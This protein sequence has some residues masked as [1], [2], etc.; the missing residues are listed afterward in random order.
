MQ[1]EISF[2]GVPLL[3]DQALVYRVQPEYNPVEPSEL[4]S[5]TKHQ[6]LTDFIDEINRLMPYQYLSDFQFPSFPSRNILGVALTDENRQPTPMIRINDFYYPNN[7]SRWAVFRG[8]ATSSMV[9]SINTAV[10]SSN[11]QTYGTFKINSV[12]KGRDSSK[13]GISTSLYMLPPRII[14]E[15]ESAEGLYL[16]T[17]VDERYFFQGTPA[18][19]PLS[20]YSTWADIINY[21]AVTL[22]ISLSFSNVLDSYQRPEPDSA[23][24]TTGE[25]AASL[26][27]AAA[28]NIGT[29]VVRNYDG[30]Y[31]LY[32]PSDSVSI[33]RS[34]R[35]NASYSLSTS[36]GA[37]ADGSVDVLRIAGGRLYPTAGISKAGDR[38]A[39]KNIV[40]PQYIHVTFPKYVAGNDPVPH[41]VNSRYRNPRATSWIEDSYGSVYSIAVPIASG[42]DLVSGLQ[43]V[44][45]QYIHETAKALYNTEAEAISFPLNYS[46][47]VDLAVQVAS[48]FYSYRI[49][50]NLDETYPGVVNWTPE[51][52]HDIIFTVSDRSRLSATR[53]IRPSWTLS[54]TELQ[55]STPIVSG[56]SYV[57]PG[58]GGTSVAQ[59]YKDSYSFSGTVL[60][61]TLGASLASG[62]FTATFTGINHLPTQN[63]W[64][65]QVENEIL[66]F[67]G[68]SGGTTVGIAQRGIDGTLQVAHDNGK[69]L[70]WI[71][72]DTA[73]G[74]NLV[75]F[76]KSQ[77]IH[78][79]TVSSGGIS[80]VTVLPQMQ[81]VLV[82]DGTG[83]VLSGITYHSGIVTYFNAA[84]A[85]VWVSGELVWITERNSGIQLTQGTR[86][87]A[88]L[89][90]YNAQIGT[91]NK[92]APVYLT[93]VGGGGGA[94]FYLTAKDQYGNSGTFLGS[95]FSGYVATTLGAP[96]NSGDTTAS[97]KDISYF[98]T[99]NRW[100]GIITWTSG[101]GTVTEKLLFEG[102]SGIGNFVGDGIEVSIVSGQRGIDGTSM[103]LVHPSGA[104]LVR[105]IIPH[106]TS[107]INTLTW[108]KSQ[109]VYPQEVS[110]E[111]GLTGVNLPALNQTIRIADGSGCVI[112]NIIHYSGV[113]TNFDPTIK[114]KPWLTT[115]YVWV[116]ERG[117]TSV[118]YSG[119]TYSG[120]LSGGFVSGSTY[121]GGNFSG[122][123]LSGFYFSGKF[124]SGI[125][126]TYV[127][128]GRYYQG[129]L[130]GYSAFESGR[131]RVVAPV[132][133]A[134]HEEESMLVQAT[135]KDYNGA[136]ITYSWHRVDEVS[137]AYRTS[138]DASP[139]HEFRLES[140]GPSSWPLYHEQNID[141]PTWP[142]YPTWRE[143]GLLLSGPLSGGFRS[144]GYSGTA[145]SGMTFSG[146][147]FS[148]ALVS[149]G[150]LQKL[151]TVRVYKGNGDYYLTNEKP[152]EDLFR[153]TATTDAYGR[154]GYLRYYDQNSGMWT[155][156]FE[157]RIADA[158]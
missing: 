126:Q 66:L 72:P 58:A 120:H 25:N 129:Q 118:S 32:T 51:G 144:Q 28:Y 39:F 34:N 30:T 77:F 38:S 124:T 86:Y 40:V 100:R 44:S 73:Y 148:G 45:Q 4:M 121:S 113:V 9:K 91:L 35:G 17:L 145:Y 60:S 46:G 50:P 1:Y 83:T 131:V 89:A 133:A 22:G 115:D 92:V 15:T 128:S 101:I 123:T 104:S 84:G 150:S 71:Q 76:G 53:V 146:Q 156:G 59:T 98:P 62:D 88:Q 157:V 136:A 105:E 139:N 69:T 135:Y 117:S 21:L 43:G 97:F 125:D 14:G 142:V 143:S 81:S 106:I 12:V 96:L 108:E 80:E 36:S 7:A 107:G 116:I 27:D 153:R 78:P 138:G 42:G 127:K 24:W 154:V 26:L 110:T 16:I 94:T 109:F 37:N 95:G 55:H 54:V 75:T 5:P 31:Q 90:G 47:L 23:L 11:G 68:T 111:S 18:T 141:L 67:E 70:T 155:D 82:L 93:N 20:P 137:A 63:R 48:D 2:A 151:S 102:T 61:T 49:A 149:G 33:A 10:A 6:P 134:T 112:N 119:L 130:V 65:G 8:L 79:N 64:K 99:Q 87:G 152:Y 74:V 56:G 3:T 147:Y 140:G 85:N 29:V 132:Y 158:Q 57:P 103:P 13:Y 114:G 122:Q 52:N 19:L 41:F